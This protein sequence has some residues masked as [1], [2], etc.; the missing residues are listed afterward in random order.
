VNSTNFQHERF[1]YVMVRTDIPLAMQPAQAMHAL[2]LAV[3]AERSHPDNYV[4]LLRAK[5]VERL[6]YAA[7]DLESAGI[8]VFRWFEP[9]GEHAGFTAWAARSVSAQ[10]RVEFRSHRLWP[11]EGV[12]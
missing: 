10:E 1:T 8:L 3:H 9:D 6:C 5:R 7:D 2:A 4:I 11:G 12:A